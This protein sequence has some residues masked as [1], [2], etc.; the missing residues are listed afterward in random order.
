MNAMNDL[1]SD[2][3]GRARTV[4]EAAGGILGL[5]SKVSKSEQ[6]MLEELAHAFE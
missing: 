4:A 6:A 2:L 5:G 3:L 1:K